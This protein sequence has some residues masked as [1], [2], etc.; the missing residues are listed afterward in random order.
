MALTS[1]P[2]PLPGEMKHAHRDITFQLFVGY[3]RRVR[4]CA[5]LANCA[6]V[7][8]IRDYLGFVQSSRQGRG[9]G[10][11]Q[12][13]HKNSSTSG[14]RVMQERPGKSTCTKWRLLGDVDSLRAP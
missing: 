1:F 9:F 7:S 8:V 6:R 14:W 11:S 2:L 10:A 3:L 4:F 5:G 13:G 12:G